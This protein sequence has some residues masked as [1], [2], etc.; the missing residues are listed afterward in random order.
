MRFYDNIYRAEHTYC[1]RCGI[2]RRVHSDRQNK[3][4][5]DCKYTLRYLGE[6]EQWLEPDDEEAA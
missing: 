1:I 5:R 3:L 6:L 2:R 4:C